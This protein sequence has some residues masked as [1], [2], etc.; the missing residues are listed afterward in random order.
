M[1][2]VF[3]MSLLIAV[4][5]T[6]A[7][8]QI[9]NPEN[10][11]RSKQITPNNSPWTDP[12]N[13]DNTVDVTE[14]SVTVKTDSGGC[15]VKVTVG[16]NDHATITLGTPGNIVVNVI[17]SGEAAIN[18]SGAGSPS[19]PGIIISGSGGDITLNGDDNYI[20]F[21]DSASD[22][23]VSVNGSDNEFDNCPDDQ[24]SFIIGIG[25]NGN[26]CV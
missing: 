10:F 13:P 11:L 17:G 6:S 16:A 19:G 7:A 1:T 5:A 26:E 22:S 12:C 18:V 25:A 15:L 20:W 23:H 21:K 24:D 4:A 3:L 9:S 2:K 14:G 8:G